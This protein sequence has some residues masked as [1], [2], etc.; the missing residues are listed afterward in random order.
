MAVARVGDVVVIESLGDVA[1]LIDGGDVVAAVRVEV[2]DRL[3]LA[4]AL[5]GILRQ[6]GWWVGGSLVEGSVAEGVIGRELAAGEGGGEG[7]DDSGHETGSY[8]VGR[9]DECLV[10]CTGFSVSPR[11]RQG[12]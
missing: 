7:G 11:C 2:H 4:V 10:A 8:Q 9:H 12:C 3:P 5:G 6:S 1:L